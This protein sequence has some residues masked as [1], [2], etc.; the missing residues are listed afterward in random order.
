[1]SKTRISIVLKHKFIDD[2]YILFANGHML[3]LKTNRYLKASL[4]VYGYETFGVNDANHKVHR[5]LAEAFIPNPYNKEF[6]D[7]IDRVKS[8]N[9]LCNLRWAS[10]SENNRNIPI[11][12]DNITG[13]DC[14]CKATE[15]M[16][17]GNLFHCWRV[18]VTAKGSV[19]MEKKFKC[20]ASDTVPPQEAI[21]CRDRFKRL[22]HG[23]FANII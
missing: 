12:A 20:K 23:T 13:Y 16:T 10:K 2:N 9:T 1:M 6:V 5:L 21:D 15:R 17:S 8:N 11:R 18:K 22:L 14:I 4:T 3:S 19:K 7:H